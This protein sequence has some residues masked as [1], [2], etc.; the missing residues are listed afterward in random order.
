MLI[1]DL[2]PS[3][4]SSLNR[5]NCFVRLGLGFR[6]LTADVEDCSLMADMFYVFLTIG[7]VGRGAS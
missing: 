7:S 1:L 6:V 4:S 2:E 5:S 3:S